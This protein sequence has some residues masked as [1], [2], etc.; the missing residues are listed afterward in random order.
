[1]KKN[2]L[3]I[4]LLFQFLNL[5]GQGDKSYKHVFY[6]KDNSLDKSLLGRDFDEVGRQNAED[7]LNNFSEQKGFPIIL[8][9]ASAYMKPTAHK[10]P[11][12][13]EGLKENTDY[14]QIQRDSL[15]HFTNQTADNIRNNIEKAI[16]SG[17]LKFPKNYVLLLLTCGET[18]YERYSEEVQGDMMHSTNLRILIDE[19]LPESIQAEVQTWEQNFQMSLSGNK[20]SNG[21]AL[22]EWLS[23][24][25][26]ED[27]L[28]ASTIQA[29]EYPIELFIILGY[30]SV[31]GSKVFY[32]PVPEDENIRNEIENTIIKKRIP[33]EVKRAGTDFTFDRDCEIESSFLKKE[34][35]KINRLRIAYYYQYSSEDDPYFAKYEDSYNLSLS[36]NGDEINQVSGDLSKIVFDKLKEGENN[37]QLIVT[38]KEGKETQT[39]DLKINKSAP[40]IPF[41]QFRI[42]AIVNGQRKE[43]LL[44]PKDKEN[45]VGN[46]K[47]GERPLA[48]GSKV[49]LE[50]F[51]LDEN[52]ELIPMENPVLFGDKTTSE[53]PIEAGDNGKI[54]VPVTHPQM[55]GN[56]KVVILTQKETGTEKFTFE[57]NDVLEVDV[58][59]LPP[60]DQED[61]KELFVETLEKIKKDN[62]D[63][64]NFIIKG[65]LPEDDAK[66]YAFKVYIVPNSHP[67]LQ[68][69]GNG[70][71]VIYG[72]ITELGKAKGGDYDLLA[73]EDLKDSKGKK[74]VL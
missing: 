42:R 48:I 9:I 68:M 24:L 60:T 31:T 58:S 50:L 41:E 14:Q 51:L 47:Y 44:E 55:K 16:Q 67:K 29:T 32:C 27:K 17:N 8:V 22:M 63:L 56:F 13:W 53:I 21:I 62:L 3:T 23:S 19:K 18:G 43:R 10:L 46:D 49:S 30:P 66:T 72:G 35:A 28:V 33:D 65:G 4:L 39:V 52:E 26:M 20:E 34:G 57:S 25:E 36:L 7:F 61:R 71:G 45:I 74:L 2:I 11:N 37:L 59:N 64:Y 73:L 69:S 38:N 1:M 15:E 5:L 40:K 54:Y 12:N 70:G 6:Y